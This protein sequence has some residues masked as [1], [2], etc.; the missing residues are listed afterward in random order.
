MTLKFGTF[1]NTYLKILKKA[2]DQTMQAKK[3]VLKTLFKNLEEE[4]SDESIKKIIRL[5]FSQS[6][7]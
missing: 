5:F 2:D 6:Y 3:R 1:K 7:D 4:V